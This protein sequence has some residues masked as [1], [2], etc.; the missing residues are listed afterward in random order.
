M[1]KF[2]DSS[3][4]KLDS[5]DLRIQ[6]LFEKVVKNFDCQPIFG[7]RS[8]EMQDT[9][10]KYGKTQVI[11]SKHNFE[12]SMAIDIH[13]YPVNEKDTKRYYH[14]AGYVLGIA[15]EM[16]SGDWFIRWGGNWNGKDVNRDLNK[17]KF[18]DLVHFEIV[19]KNA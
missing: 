14:F 15:D 10:Y 12:P 4:K 5:C 18:M 11:T 19:E 16:S 7:Y 2:S 6:L 3:K 9:L 13:P 17:Q 1:P 8:Q